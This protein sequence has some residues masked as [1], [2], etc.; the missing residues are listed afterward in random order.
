[1]ANGH[2]YHA[3]D[4]AQW[5]TSYNQQMVLFRNIPRAGTSREE[6]VFER[7]PAAPGSGLAIAIPAR[8]LAIGDLDGD[9]RLDAVVNN[10]DARPTLLRNVTKPAGHWL[11][12]RLVGDTSKKS[13]KDAMGAVAYLTTGKL[14]QRQ[15]VLSGA[16]Y[17][18]QNDARLHF[19]LGSALKVDKL[20][21]LWPD[22]TT[23]VVAVPGTDRL[24]T[25]VQGKGIAG[26]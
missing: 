18:S 6:R 21:I 9:G 23:E 20:E 11:S 15:D 14:R 10:I 2:V 19:G 1:V 26:K 24:L 25:I 7:V 13:P 5:G 22:G 4:E 17:S 3:V 16:G 12:I 8:G